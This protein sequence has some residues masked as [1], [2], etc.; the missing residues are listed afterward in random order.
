MSFNVLDTSRGETLFP[1]REIPAQLAARGIGGC[2]GKSGKLSI[3]TIIRWATHGLSGKKLEVIRAGRGLHTSV[4][5]V[6][7]LFQAATET[8]GQTEPAPDPGNQHEQAEAYLAS[9]RI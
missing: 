8:D 3:H 2:S 7:R 9:Q 4:E 6:M 5:A 1:L